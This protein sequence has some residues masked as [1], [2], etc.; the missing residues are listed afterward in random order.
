MIGPNGAGKTTLLRMLA[1]RSSRRGHDRTGPQRR[2]RGGRPAPGRGARPDRTVLEEFRTASASGT[3]EV[4][5]RSMLGAFGF[6]GDLADR[7]G[8]EAVRRRAHPPRARQGDGVAGQPAAARRADQPPRPGQPRRARGRLNAYPGTVVLITHDRHVIRGVADAIVEVGGGIARWFDGTYEELRGAGRDAAPGP[9]D[10]APRKSRRAAAA[11][12]PAPPA[13]RRGRGQAPRRRAAQRATLGPPRT[14]DARR[15]R[16]RERPG[17]VEAGWP[18]SPGRSAD[19]AVYADA[20]RVKRLVAAH[21]RGQGPGRRMWP[22]GRP[23][24][25]GSNRPRTWAP[26]AADRSAGAAR[27]RGTAARPGGLVHPVTTGRTAPARFAVVT[28]GAGEPRRT[29]TRSRTV[30][31]RTADGHGRSRWDANG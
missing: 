26:V 25:P 28:D 19:P 17:E 7:R 3:D 22:P 31:W 23:P 11:P 9:G 10:V 21:G 4:N 12:A 18:S 30:R 8:G 20:E 13:A 6:P 1:G 2:R 24:R 5:H 27:G 29:V 15:S 16:A 14:C